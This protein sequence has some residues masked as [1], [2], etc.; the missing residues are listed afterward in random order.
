MA[1][2][3][4]QI[5]GHEQAIQSWVADKKNNHLHHALLIVGPPGIGKKMVARAFAQILLC[6]KDQTGCGECGSCKRVEA[7]AHESLFFVGEEQGA[8]KVET[9]HHLRDF[10]SLQKLSKARVILIERADQ[11]LPAAANV[12]LKT[13]EEPPEDTYFFMLAPSSH[14]LLPTLRS[15]VTTMRLGPL[16]ADEVAKKISAPEWVLAAGRGRFDRIES[17]KSGEWKVQREFHS[18]LLLGILSNPDWLLSDWRKQVPPKTEWATMFE[19]WLS[20]IRDAFV[21]KSGAKKQI[22]NPDQA[23]AI[24]QLQALSIDEL[25]QAAEFILKTMGQSQIHRDPVLLLEQF[26]LTMKTGETHVV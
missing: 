21:A 11:F 23:P 24:I 4:D 14:H 17:F 1:R 12:I 15:R 6:E 2:L 26:F 16:P 22:V 20:L 19:Y 7:G 3:L 18:Q 9:S 25:D 8:I 13:L 5:V 10:L